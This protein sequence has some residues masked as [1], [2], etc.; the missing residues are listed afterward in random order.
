MNDQTRILLRLQF[1]CLVSLLFIA[2]HHASRACAEMTFE[3]SWQLPEY[4]DVRARVVE[5]IEHE[6]MQKEQNEK[7]Y[8][9]WPL[10]DLR[11]AEGTSLLERVIETFG[12]DD[13]RARVLMDE[14][15]AMASYP[16]PPDA[17]WI[18]DPNMSPFKRNNLKL[19]YARWLAQHNHYEA[20]IQ[21][22]EDL[23]PIHVVDP[24]GLLFYRA[25]AYQ[26]LVEPDNSRVALVQLLER[27]EEL[28]ERF[29]Q[30]ARLLNHD[31]SGL[32]DDSLDHVARRM[33]D[34]RRRLNIGHAGKQVRV[35]EKD[36]LDSLDRMIEKLEQQQQ[37]QSSSSGGAQ[38]QQPMPDSRLP[39]M[40]APMQVDQR[41]IGSQSDWGDLPPKEREQALQQIGREFPAHY[42][43]LIEQYFR[44][45]ADDTN[46]T[47]Q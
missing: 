19:Y 44:E 2:V 36:V 1:V 31:L 32:K 5:W 30:V 16:V 46:N 12:L 28:P 47:S 24:A 15:N 41:D 45:L 8:S 13:T 9:L 3:P 25:V 14:C 26:Q 43:E 23:K 33:N 35:V 22:L 27:E 38:G 39:S 17:Y 40:H 42:R 4:E 7:A 37:Q 18:N 21:V 34:V 6:D 20:V 10:A 29:M 11:K